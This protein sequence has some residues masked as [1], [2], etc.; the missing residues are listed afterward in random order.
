MQLLDVTSARHSPMG[1]RALSPL[2]LHERIQRVLQKLECRQG[3]RGE[4]LI[5]GPRAPPPPI[6]LDVEPP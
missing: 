3:S 2:V 1:D 5:S 6:P 4:E